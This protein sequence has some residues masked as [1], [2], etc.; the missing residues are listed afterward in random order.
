MRTDSLEAPQLPAGLLIQLL[1]VRA[2]IR[3]PP[4]ESR[5]SLL[6]ALRARW[7]LGKGEAAWYVVPP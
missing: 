1:L 7:C 4:L 3:R 6:M 2:R 5:V